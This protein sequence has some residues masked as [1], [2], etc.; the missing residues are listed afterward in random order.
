MSA[1]PSEQINLLS[2]IADE[3]TGEQGKDEK[4]S[5]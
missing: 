1:P 5:I 2:H 3:T 4:V